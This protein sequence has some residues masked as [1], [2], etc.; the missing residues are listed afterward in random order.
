METTGTTKQRGKALVAL[1]AA[2]FSLASAAPAAAQYGWPVKPFHRQHPVRAY[3]GDPRIGNDHGYVAHT[4]HFGIDIYAANGT[5]VY[6][7]IS[8]RI[9]IHP[10]HSDTVL[11][12]SGSMTLEY[13]HVVP[14]VR[15]GYAVAYKTIIGHV[16]K[17]WAHV[18]FSERYGSTYVNPLRAGALTPYRDTTKPTVDS[19][20][21]QVDQ[22]VAN[23]HDTT[24]LPVPAPWNDKP[25][26]P[27]LVE[28]RLLGSDVAA[29]G[30]QVA[31]DFRD[32]LPG[33]GFSSVY[34]SNTT[35]NHAAT[36]GVYTYVLAHGWSPAGLR[37]GRYV[38]QVRVADTDGNAA[39][40]SLRFIVRG[41]V[42]RPSHT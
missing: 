35:Q 42:A 1:A 30:W 16:E 17:P 7:T 36:V 18:H 33:V 41:G 24:P 26:T 3:F 19:I 20:R 25:V 21:I 9:S 12:Q 23:A 4:L 2:A 27:A 8:G 38:L 10:L 13:W 14:A 29:R 34:A 39:V 40:R 32:A 5:P 11:V 15:S 31:A 6:A 22:I 37:A 28:W